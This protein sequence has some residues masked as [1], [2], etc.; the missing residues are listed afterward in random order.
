MPILR[1]GGGGAAGP[2]EQ[3]TTTDAGAGANGLYAISSDTLVLSTGVLD[4]WKID[5]NSLT[6]TVTESSTNDN[7][8]LA[9]TVGGAL[10]RLGTEEQAANNV[11]LLYKEI[12]DGSNFDLKVRLKGSTSAAQ[13]NDCLFVGTWRK[14]ENSSLTNYLYKSPSVGVHLLG[15]NTSLSQIWPRAHVALASG[16]EL[17]ALEKYKHSVD[18]DTVRWLRVKRTAGLF[19]YY[20]Q[21]DATDD[22]D[23]GTW[24]EVDTTYCAH[25][26][27]EASPHN[28]DWCG[29]GSV[30]GIA[31]G[32]AASTAIKFYIERIIL[33]YTAAAD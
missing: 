29:A 17:N 28:N 26:S 24:V 2:S 16:V 6:A 12:V 15:F 5:K 3:T 32:G 18:T 25:G 23:S 31:V 22:P 8:E 19:N 21:E 4:G 13:G 11:L 27:G 1:R 30:L 33:T 10:M 9:V 20:T 14:E 7:C